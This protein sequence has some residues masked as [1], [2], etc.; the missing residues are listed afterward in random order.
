MLVVKRQYRGKR[1]FDLAV[2]AIVALPA[3]LVGACCAVAIKLTSRG[4]VFFRQERIGWGGEAF[5]VWK[6]RSLVVGDHS[7]LH[8]AD[9]VTPV[10]RILRRTSLDELPQLVNVLRGEMSIVGPRPT[11]RSQVVLYDARQAQRLAVRPGLTGLAQV[12]GRNSLMWGERIELDLQYVEQQ[13]VRVD[14][15]LVVRTAGTVVGGDGVEGHPV[16]D[17]L[18]GLEPQEVV[19]DLREPAETD[20][21]AQ[22]DLPTHA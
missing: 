16:D 7:L 15:G 10:G 20:A 17:P 4:P 5:Q 14:L 22:A 11:V 8:S 6:F 12:S 19:I 9:A 3:L 13:S 2:L 1:A 21:A 18:L